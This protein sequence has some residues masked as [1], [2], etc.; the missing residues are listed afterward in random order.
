MA[1][2]QVVWALQQ[3]GPASFCLAGSFSIAAATPFL[4]AARVP[5]P[6]IYF[7]RT[8]EPETAS[9]WHIVVRRHLSIDL[10]TL[11]PRAPIGSNRYS[12]ASLAGRCRNLRQRREE[13]FLSPVSQGLELRARG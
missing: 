10:I 12:D 5:M 2:P 4:L 3:L 11:H 9:H 6:A 8:T 7:P 13:P 1:G